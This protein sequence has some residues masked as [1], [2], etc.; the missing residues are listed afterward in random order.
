M[1]VRTHSSTQRVSAWVLAAVCRSHRGGHGSGAR[2]SVSDSH[3]LAW[4]AISSSLCMHRVL[5]G[6]VL[7]QPSPSCLS[8]AWW[9]IRSARVV[10]GHPA[11]SH[12]SSAIFRYV[13][14]GDEKLE[15]LSVHSF[16]HTGSNRRPILVSTLLMSTCKHLCMW[17]R[18]HERK[19][20]L[21][22]TD[23]HGQD[24]GWLC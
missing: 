24:E 4:L 9:E 14:D 18:C 16:R 13:G 2:G 7:V 11:P 3:I 8:V 21:R 6:Q 10:C 15:R 1:H 5:L 19:I 12:P 22:C 17:L 20:H 23:V